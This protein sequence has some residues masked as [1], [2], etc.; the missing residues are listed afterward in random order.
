MDI[1]TIFDNSE[2]RRATVYLF[3]SSLTHLQTPVGQV[4]TVHSSD[5]DTHITDL[6]KI[7]S[8][9]CTVYSVYV[10]KF[11]IKITNFSKYCKWLVFS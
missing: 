9:A 1:Y 7:Q 8:P 4:G 3:Q 10:S 5:P 2:L 6:R 11:D